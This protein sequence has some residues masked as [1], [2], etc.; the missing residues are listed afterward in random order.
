MGA[1]ARSRGV[2]PRTTCRPT[3]A[4]AIDPRAAPPPGVARGRGGPGVA[5][6]AGSRVASSGPGADAPGYVRSPLTGLPGSPPRVLAQHHRTR[7][8]LRRLLAPS[9]RIVVVINEESRRSRGIFGGRRPL[10]PI[11]G[12]PDGAGADPTQPGPRSLVSG[13]RDRRTSAAPV[14][15]GSMALRHRFRPDTDFGRHRFR[16]PIPAERVGSRRIG[17]RSPDLSH[18]TRSARWMSGAP[19]SGRSGM[20]RSGRPRGTSGALFR[21]PVLVPVL[22]LI[23]YNR[24]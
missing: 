10:G 9:G 21:S 18:F 6:W 14:R 23:R 4:A 3:P 20:A 24:P 11:G 8:R 1:T 7:A 16:P 17:G 15:P 2:S 13:R 19:A 12:S 5:G 22:R